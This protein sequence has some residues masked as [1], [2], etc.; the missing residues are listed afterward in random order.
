MTRKVIYQFEGDY[1]RLDIGF[2]GVDE[3]RICKAESKGEIGA[4]VTDLG[5]RL[6]K[7]VDDALNKCMYK[8]ESVLFSIT[9]LAPEEDHGLAKPGAEE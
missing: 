5:T 9:L 1:D 8:G 4:N 3:T 6:K 2:K 7:V